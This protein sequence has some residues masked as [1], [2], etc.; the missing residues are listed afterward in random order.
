MI[1]TPFITLF[2]LS[3]HFI[4]I[5]FW[6]LIN[7]LKNYFTLGQ[8]RTA[9]GEAKTAKHIQLEKNRTQSVR[10]HMFEVCIESTFQVKFWKIPLIFSS[11]HIHYFQPLLQIY[12]YLPSFLENSVCFSFKTIKEKQTLP[13]LQFLA[14]VTSVLSLTFSFTKYFI[15]KQNG[16]M[17]L[18]FNP[19]GCLT[20][21]I[22]T[23]MQ[24]NIKMSTRN[25]KL[26]F[27][28]FK[29]LFRFWAVQ[30]V[31]VCLL[32]LLERETFGLWWSSLQHMFC[33]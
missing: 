21:L 19:C 5:L 27:F 10:A 12:L 7:L 30:C 29:I 14:I 22:S 33:W 1:L 2:W 11:W 31:W 13:H 8:Y 24:V 3:F 26:S 9:V 15:M 18:D 23:L 25:K 16:A 17:D 20:I 6:P 32:T 28:I 4:W